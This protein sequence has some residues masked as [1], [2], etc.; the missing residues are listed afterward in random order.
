MSAIVDETSIPAK[1]MP[2]VGASPTTTNAPTPIIAPSEIEYVPNS[3]LHKEDWFHGP[4]SRKQSE[5]LVIRDGDFLVR[6]SQVSSGQYVLTGMQSGS[7]KHL[8]LV[9]PEGV[10]SYPYSMFFF[11]QFLLF[12]SIY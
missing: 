4:I 9:D 8:L 6:E 12:V 2:P 5:E 3:A 10:V 7:R 11:P 1:R